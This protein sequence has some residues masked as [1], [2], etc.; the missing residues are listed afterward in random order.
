[1]GKSIFVTGTG[2]DIGKT[3]VTALIV[4]KISDSGFSAGYY[5]AA[6]S[7]EL[8]EGIA[9]D[10][11]EVKKVAGL[12]FD[13]KK[14]ISYVYEDSVSPHLAAKISN[15]P[16]N[17]SVIERDFFYA[18]DQFD[19]LTV[20]GSGGVICPLR[21]DEKNFLMLDDVI[22]NLNLSV[23][24][25]IDSKL[26]EINSA[27]LT[28]EHLRAKNI[29]IKGLIFN[30]FDEKNLIH[31]DNKEVIEELTNLKTLA[32]VNKNS[33]ELDIDVKDLIKLYD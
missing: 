2:T 24:V 21:R 13:M 4:K 15:R 3:F 14:Y 28:V 30:R 23:I 1:M 33:N 29:S 22:K 20:E 19:F 31:R 32:T 27:V 12:N 10:A 18:R 26:G 8:I 25:V 11:F 7:G 5:K 16:I 9:A 17:F 6:A